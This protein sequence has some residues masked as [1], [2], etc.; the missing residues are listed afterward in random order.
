[1]IESESGDVPDALP[2]ASIPALLRVARRRLSQAQWDYIEQGAGAESTVQRNRKA[3]DRWTFTPRLLAPG[4]EPD[5]TTT[6]GD[7][8]LSMPVIC[9]PF[10]FGRFIHP[11]GHVG[12]AHAAAAEGTLSIVPEATSVSLEEI[13]AAGARPG[14]LQVGLG[15]GEERV[16]EYV[17]RAADAGYA[18]IVFTHMPVAAWRERQREHHLDLEPYGRGNDAGFS[19]AARSAPRDRRW[20]WERLAE[21]APRMPLPWIVKGIQRADQARRA[22]EAGAAGVYVSN[23]GGRNLDG[24]PPALDALAEVSAEVAGRVPVVFDGGVRRGSDVVKAVALGADIVAVGRLAAFALGAAGV[25]GVRTMLALLRDEIV[26]TCYELGVG[27]IG[28]LGA[29][30]VRELNGYAFPPLDSRNREISELDETS[31]RSG[32]EG[33]GA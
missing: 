30:H 9:A 33:S 26:A 1:V 21:L 17:R 29:E 31:V 32:P 24:L 20:D 5:L 27:P 2:A 14:Y 12:V 25:A 6:L 19:N 10:G 28:D 7:C 4:P 16:L 3:F 11:D 8:T 22:I 23:F 13:A 18:G 15:F